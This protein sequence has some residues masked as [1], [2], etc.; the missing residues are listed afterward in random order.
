MNKMFTL[1]AVLPVI[2][3][4]FVSIFFIPAFIN[5]YAKQNIP[6]YLS[7]LKPSKLVEYD[8]VF[9][10]ELL[11]TE[12]FIWPTPNYKTITSSYGYRKA[13]ASGA[14]TFHGGIDIGAAEGSS[15]LALANGKVTFAGW[16]GA[17]GYTVKINYGDGIISTYGHVNPDFLVS[18]GDTVYQGD[19]VAR[20]GPKYV[21]KKSYTTYTDSTGKATNGAT[22]GPHLH[23]AITKNGKRINPQEIYK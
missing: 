8:Y 20:V 16:N 7:F 12:D 15:I 2:I 10:Q 14:A 19:I 21:E 18:A 11:S 5:F 9:S 22:T 3:I 17:N 6:V 23:F 13:P 4:I 1:S